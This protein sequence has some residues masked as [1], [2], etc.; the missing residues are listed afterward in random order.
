ME[1]REVELS[2]IL[3][4]E[5]IE[6]LENVLEEMWK[7]RIS[8]LQPEFVNNLKD[9]FRKDRGELI[10]KG[11]DPDYLAYAVLYIL[12]KLPPDTWKY[13]LKAEKEKAR[14]KLGEAL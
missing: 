14:K 11:V 3:T 8:V 7:K 2:E 12:S 13:W 5:Q 1:E 4:P 6:K 9:L 10:K